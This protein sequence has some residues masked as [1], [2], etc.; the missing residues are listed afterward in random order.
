MRLR[1]LVHA[2]HVGRADDEGGR[3]ATRAAALTSFFNARVSPA[4]NARV[5]PA[6]NSL[7]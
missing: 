2:D 7:E 3:E 5:S 4:F 1:V 6:F